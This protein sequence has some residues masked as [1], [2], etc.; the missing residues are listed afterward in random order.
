[1]SSE[2]LDILDLDIDNYSVR[3]LENFFHFSSQNKYTLSDIETREYKI[4]EQLLSSGQVNRR[5]KRDL[6]EFLKVAKERLVQAKCAPIPPPTTMPDNVKLDPYDVPRSRK[7]PPRTDMMIDHPNASYVYTNPSE[8]FHGDLNPLN[9]R[10]LTKCLNID[11]R[12]RENP[13]LTQS[14][15]FMIQLPL[16]LYK[17]VS[18][19]LSSIEFTTEFYTIM[20][21]YGNNFLYM[22]VQHLPIV[23]V[24]TE[25]VMEERVFTISDGVYS[26]QTLIDA[27]NLKICP[28]NPD[29]TVK[30]PEDVFSYV[31]LT[32]DLTEL[33]T[34]TSK[35][36]IRANGFYEDKIHAIGLDFTKDEGNCIDNMDTRSKIGWN[37]GFTKQVYQGSTTYVGEAAMNV[38]TLPFVY[39]CIEDFNNS[40]NYFISVFQKSMM[41]QDVLARVSTKTSVLDRSFLQN[42]DWTITTEPRRYFGPVD[43]QRLRIRL[44]DEFGRVVQMN[45]A[46]FS[47]CLTIK[48]IYDL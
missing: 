9:T 34:G 25:V 29:D 30:F 16:K 48:M 1:M 41:S 15:D 31:V 8:F 6:I 3:D 27:L 28:R 5:Y 40:S 39:L 17:V 35:V 44:Y 2:K 24:S 21:E 14:S 32:L 22:K 46:D 47:F 43:I 4:R 23:G 13:Q 19:E 38:Y 18:L 45:H 42:S 37:L 11:T 7:P 10:I 26:K 33:G 12:F 20:T 36:T